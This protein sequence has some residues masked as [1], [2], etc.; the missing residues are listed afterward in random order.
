ME[1]SCFECGSIA[2]HDH[3]VV[4][5]SR[6]GIKTVPLCGPCHARVHGL[7]DEWG[8]NHGAL[9]RDGLATKRARGGRS[10]NLPFGFSHIDGR[11]ILNVREQAVIAAVLIMH[12]EGLSLRTITDRLAIAKHVGR[13]G[14]PLSRS[15]VYR[16]V[17]SGWPE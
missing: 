11:L 5:R 12:A 7:A 15:Q 13:T 17:K 2:E 6:G 4:P 9:T 8:A 14:K 16:I 3:H 1:A 10:G